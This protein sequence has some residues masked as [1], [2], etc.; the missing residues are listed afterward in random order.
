MDHR[1]CIVQ[2]CEEMDGI[3]DVA[4][5]NRDIRAQN[6]DIM[7]FQQQWQLDKEDAEVSKALELLKQKI[8]MRTAPSPSLTSKE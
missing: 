7:Q 6:I 4:Q 8:Q 2:F 3:V 5:I 1:L